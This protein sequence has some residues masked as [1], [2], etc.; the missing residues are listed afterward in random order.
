[1]FGYIMHT[2]SLWYLTLCVRQKTAC[3]CLFLCKC[4]SSW[5]SHNKI[6]GFVSCC[7]LYHVSIDIRLYTIKVCNAST[8]RFYGIFRT[9]SRHTEVFIEMAKW[10]KFTT[11]HENHQQSIFHF[12]SVTMM[13][14]STKVKRKKGNFTIHYHLCNAIS[15]WTHYIIE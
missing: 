14:F 8:H 7:T 15:Q 9:I 12:F 11:V 5:C 2:L 13:V 4:C 3:I 6:N 1:M 10:Q